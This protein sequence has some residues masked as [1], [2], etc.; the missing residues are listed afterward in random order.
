MTT[1]APPLPD[2]ELRGRTTV[3]DRAVERLAAAAAAEVDLATGS[4]RR[5]L[6]LPVSDPDRPRVTARVHGDEATVEVDLAV[7][8]P[9]PVGQVARRVRA[10]VAEQLA[11][12]AGLRAVRVDVRVTAL[13]AQRAPERPRV[14]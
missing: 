2:P 10:R 9:A 3:A 8:W 14:R 6:G 4:A 11:D 1:S 13:P 5:V 7:A 12:L